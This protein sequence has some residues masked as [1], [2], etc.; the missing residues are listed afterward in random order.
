MQWCRCSLTVWFSVVANKAI[1]QRS[2]V[3]NVRFCTQA[4]IQGI[5]RYPLLL[6]HGCKVTRSDD[7]TRELVLQSQHNI[8]HCLELINLYVIFVTT[9][10]LLIYMWL[11]FISFVYDI[12]INFQAGFLF[13]CRP[14]LYFG[15][16]LEFLKNIPWMTE[17]QW[18]VM[19]AASLHTPPPPS[20]AH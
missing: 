15:I 7:E 20:L 18:F 8:E 4:S 3:C 10:S 5:T 2:T 14:A 11:D 12:F 9:L 19:V 6:A 1:G 17:V 16:F 13:T